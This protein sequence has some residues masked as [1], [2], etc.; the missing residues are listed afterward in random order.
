[1]GGGEGGG[2]VGRREGSANY[3]KIATP[4][5]SRGNHRQRSYSSWFV[6][7]LEVIVDLARSHSS[8]SFN[9][10]ATLKENANHNIIDLQSSVSFEI[11]S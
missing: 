9:F 1:M 2:L 11:S 6:H 7:L 10:L 3:E 4:K 8:S 5:S